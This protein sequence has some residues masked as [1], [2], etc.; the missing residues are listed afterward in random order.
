MKS[1]YFIILTLLCSCSSNERNSNRESY[2]LIISLE[3]CDGCRS[4][5]ISFMRRNLDN[6]NLKFVIST[7]PSLKK[8]PYAI[9]SQEELSRTNV[10]IDSGFLYTQGH[11]RGYPILLGLDSSGH[12]ISELELTGK[13]IDSTLSLISISQN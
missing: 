4:S 11:T 2:C 6:K 8:V 5:A 12:I 9:F 7:P 13:N 1:L 10:F 3:G